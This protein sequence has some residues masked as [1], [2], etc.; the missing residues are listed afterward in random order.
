M[1][2]FNPV[3]TR[4]DQQHSASE[5]TATTLRFFPGRPATVIR[6]T[7]I[8][9]GS[10]SRRGRRD[11]QPAGRQSQGA[12]TTAAVRPCRSPKITRA[13]EV[14]TKRG[15]TSCAP[16]DLGASG[17]LGLCERHKHQP[18]ASSPSGRPQSPVRG[19]PRLARRAVRPGAGRRWPWP[20]ALPRSPL[21]AV[22]RELI[23][24]AC[25]HR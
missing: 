20:G 16:D 9:R 15:T 19:P 25:G 1:V 17:R 18:G 6:A 5:P 7:V 2:G 4:S 22:R 12:R 24:S 11:R 23:G 14:Q 13:G 3:I 8:R 10:F 21:R